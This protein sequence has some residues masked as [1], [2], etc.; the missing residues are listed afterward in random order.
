MRIFIFVIQGT[1]VNTWCFAEN[2]LDGHALQGYAL[3]LSSGY[4]LASG[5]LAPSLLS[6]KKVST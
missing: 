1:G 2:V 3:L 5:G 6:Y 4:R